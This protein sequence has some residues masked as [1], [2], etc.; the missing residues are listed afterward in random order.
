MLCSVVE[1]VACV[2]VCAH[3]SGIDIAVVN[4]TIRIL[5]LQ[6]T[7]DSSNYGS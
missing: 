3:S 1:N 6:E 7:D 2:C 5:C 4:F